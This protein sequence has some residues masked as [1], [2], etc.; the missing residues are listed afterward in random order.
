MTV[1]PGGNILAAVDGSLEAR[2]AVDVAAQLARAWDAELHVVHVWSG[3]ASNLTAV[4]AAAAARR[5]LADEVT[6]AVGR[7]ATVSEQHFLIGAAAAGIAELGEELAAILCVLGQH[8]QSR[9]GRMV[10]GS[11][12]AELLRATRRPLLF[13]TSKDDWPPRRVLVG[14]DGSA[15][16][17]GAA[18][19]GAEIGR[20]YH[21]EVELMRAAGAT[22]GV[23]HASAGPVAAGEA[24]LT[25]DARRLEDSTGTPVSVSVVD[26]S[27]YAAL[28]GGSTHGRTLVAVGTRQHG[29][30]VHWMEGSVSREL[31][32]SAATLLVVPP[33]M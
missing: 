15:A 25:A 19:M 1:A 3:H 18:M 23:E 5:L 8:R 17:L 28:Q 32:H 27:P 22:L 24:S 14:D 9:V 21:A 10:F 33:T 7:G 31:V 13:V 2:D 11:V 12:N 29:G 30:L 20:L 6:N 16:S 26:A 4:V